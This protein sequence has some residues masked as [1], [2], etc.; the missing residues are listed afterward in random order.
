MQLLKHVMLLCCLASILP[1]SFAQDLTPKEVLSKAENQ[2]RG[3][4]SKSIIKMTIVRPKWQR[5]MVMK[6][7]SKGDDY[8]LILITSPARDKG[9]SFLKREKDLWSWRP[10]IGRTVKMPPSMMSQSWMGSDFTNDDLVR[11]SSIVK[12]YDHK[13]LASE[14]IEGRDCYKIE[15]LPKAE[16]S[17]IWG[18]VIMWISKEHF[19]QMKTQFYDEDDYLVNTILGKNVKKFGTRYLPAKM[20]MIPEEKKGDRTIIEYESLEFGV[21]TSDSFFSIQNMKKVR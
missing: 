6:S 8:S 1:S 2:L 3:E 16:S 11:Q 13:F 10:N 5:T 17:V 18:K 12:D 7:W 21:N 14:K 9:I 4:S 15:L 20:E 19:L